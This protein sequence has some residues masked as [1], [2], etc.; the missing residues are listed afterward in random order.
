MS[1]SVSLGR[2]VNLFFLRGQLNVHAWH[3]SKF[4][5]GVNENK[6]KWSYCQNKNFSGTS[7]IIRQLK[8]FKMISNEMPI[9]LLIHVDDILVVCDIFIEIS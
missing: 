7:D 1:T 5:D 8:T 2:I 9:L 3:H 4:T 6:Q